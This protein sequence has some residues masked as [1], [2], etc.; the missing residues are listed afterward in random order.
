LPLVFV[1]YGQRTILS[2]TAT[3]FRVPLCAVECKLIEGISGSEK[4]PLSWSLRSSFVVGD[5]AG[6]SDVKGEA[7]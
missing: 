3:E 2:T 7:V 5:L 6:E 1:S 4:V